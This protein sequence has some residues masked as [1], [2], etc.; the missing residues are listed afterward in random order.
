M[1]Q[2]RATDQLLRRLLDEHDL[3]LLANA[4]TPAELAPGMVVTVS[5][6]RAGNRPI[7]R[8]FGAVFTP[9]IAPVLTRAAYVPIKLGRSSSALTAE[10]VAKAAGTLG[11]ITPTDFRAALD[12]GDARRAS[13][14]DHQIGRHLR[15]A[16]YTDLGR[17]LYED[18]NQFYLIRTVIT[19][20]E[21]LISGGQERAASLLA[22]L[23]PILEGKAYLAQHGEAQISMSPI[24]EEMVVG[25]SA[26]EIIDHPNGGFTLNGL[27]EPLRQLDDGPSTAKPAPAETFSLDGEEPITSIAKE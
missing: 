7:R 25:F 3:C 5:R 13:L 22:E 18:G 20:A 21:V 17:E 27:T 19:A 1:C 10:L 4:L 8:P 23:K 11:P 26:S 2:Q 16:A 12:F 24:D 6:V 9:D 14:D 15:T